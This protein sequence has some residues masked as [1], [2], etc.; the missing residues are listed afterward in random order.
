M[1]N[2]E[3]EKRVEV[4][5]EARRLA[6]ELFFESSG[7]IHASDCVIA[8]KKGYEHAQSHYEAKWRDHTE[9]TAIVLAE[10]ECERSREIVAQCGQRLN[11]LTEENAALKS[12]AAEREK[13]NTMLTTELVEQ[14]AEIAALHSRL[15]LA[16]EALLWI[17]DW[18]PQYCQYA[19][20]TLSKMGYVEK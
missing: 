19:A 9:Y 11:L 5:F 7:D 17:R 4:D 15:T 1:T 18:S 20:E 8:F 14:E 2:E 12:Q 16:T 3:I 6:G 13:T 10:E